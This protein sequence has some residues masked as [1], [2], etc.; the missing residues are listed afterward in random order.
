MK[1]FLGVTLDCKCDMLPAADIVST[2]PFKHEKIQRT[3]T[4]AY[5]DT[6]SITKNFFSNIGP[7]LNGSRE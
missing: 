4:L 2:V 3:N 1:H 7:R 6:R 5:F